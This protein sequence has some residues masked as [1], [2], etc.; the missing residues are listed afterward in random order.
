MSTNPAF[1]FFLATYNTV[2]G[3]TYDVVADLVTNGPQYYIA[4]WISLLKN[5]PEHLF[6]ETGLI[7]FI[8]WLVFIRRTV[9]PIKSSKDSLSK[10]EVA[11]LIETWQPEPLVPSASQKDLLPDTMI[12][13]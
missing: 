1:E 10:K 6:I 2:H 5:A 9:D 7:A 11:W 4:W 12:V 8:F 3:L 13:S